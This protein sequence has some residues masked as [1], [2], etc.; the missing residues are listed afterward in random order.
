MK[1][2]WTAAAIDDLMEIREHWKA[3]SKEYAAKLTQDIRATVAALKEWPDHQG[4]YIKELEELNLTQYRQLLCGKYR[5]IFERV[6]SANAFYIHIVCHTPRA[7]ESIL[8][9]RQ[10]GT[11]T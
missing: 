5:I 3:E 2:D 6:D 7:L 10:L 1:I 8:R 4:T 11:R 9:R